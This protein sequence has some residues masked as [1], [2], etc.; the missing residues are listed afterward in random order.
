[1]KTIKLKF[2][3]NAVFYKDVYVIIGDG[4]RFGLLNELGQ[5]TGASFDIETNKYKDFNRVTVS[6]RKT[7]SGDIV[8]ETFTVVN[9]VEREFVL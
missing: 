1:M 8:S 9:E 4:I 2:A 7:G 5:F 3:R 6:Y